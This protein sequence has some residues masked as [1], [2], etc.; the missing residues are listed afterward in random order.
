MGEA[1]KGG[2]DKQYKD[3]F[4]RFRH[5]GVCARDISDGVKELL[6]GKGWRETERERERRGKENCFG[7]K[8]PELIRKCIRAVAVAPMDEGSDSDAIWKLEMLINAQG[9]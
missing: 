9:N 4:I 3:G 7:F 6:S 8:Y 5:I 1:G 2:G